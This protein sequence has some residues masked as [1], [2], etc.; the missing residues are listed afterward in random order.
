ME[1]NILLAIFWIKRIYRICKYVK[2]NLFEKL[3]FS[4][5]WVW[6][7][8]CDYDIA[9]VQSMFSNKKESLFR[10]YLKVEK[11]KKKKKNSLLHNFFWDYLFFR[12]SGK[13]SQHFLF[14]IIFFVILV[15][16]NNF[17]KSSLDSFSLLI[18]SYL[19][20]FSSVNMFIMLQ[21]L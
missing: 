21:W 15:N 10:N 1:G 3:K 17:F 14:F 20:K 18:N 19:W 7:L 6:K 11:S 13:V 9:F 4:C 8:Y 2:N 16:K 12:N 5:N